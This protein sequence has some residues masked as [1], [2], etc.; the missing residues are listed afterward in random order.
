MRSTEC[1]DQNISIMNNI[2]FSVLPDNVYDLL[3]YLYNGTSE[4]TIFI[5]VEIKI[6]RSARKYYR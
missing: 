4:V 5:C 3:I 2:E 6:L 1:C